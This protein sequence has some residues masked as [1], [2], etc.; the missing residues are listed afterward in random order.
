M[1]LAINVVLL[2]VFTHILFFTF[3]KIFKIVPRLL[4]TIDQSC[5]ICKRFQFEPDLIYQS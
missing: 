3:F 1:S 5:L 2:H 4:H